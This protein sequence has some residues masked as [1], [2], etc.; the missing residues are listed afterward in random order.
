MQMPVMLAWIAGIEVRRMPPET[1]ISAWIP[2][3]HA[4]MTMRRVRSTI[5]PPEWLMRRNTDAKTGS[6][7]Q[8]YGMPLLDALRDPSGESVILFD[9]GLRSRLLVTLV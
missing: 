8:G 3:L 1:S 4:G 2:A 9:C 5:E 7:I 6:D